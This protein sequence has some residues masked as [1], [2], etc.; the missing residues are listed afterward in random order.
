MVPRE[1]PRSDDE[2]IITDPLRSLSLREVDHP[3]SL[4]PREVQYGLRSEHQRV[5]VS[6]LWL[7]GHDFLVAL[8]KS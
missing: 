2:C 7:L 5:S 4:L 6:T 3:F 8:V 1:R